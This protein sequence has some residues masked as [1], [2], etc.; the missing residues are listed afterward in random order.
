MSASATSPD[1]GARLR[2]AREARGVSLRQVANAT[3][4]AVGVLEAL[5]RNDFSKLPGGIFS[6]AF[7]RAYAQ[8]VGLDPEETVREFLAALP[9]DTS[10]AH[11]HAPPRPVDQEEAA[12]QSRQRMAAVALRL[13]LVSLPIAAALVYF[14]TRQADRSGAP[15]AAPR[16]RTSVAMPV[17]GEVRG[18]SE[19]ELVPRTGAAVS[20]PVAPQ[21]SP[22]A[23]GPES[24]DLVLEIAPVGICW[25]S[26]TADG[27]LVFARI[28]APGERVVQRI[29][30][31]AA[32]QVGDAG[33]FAFAINGRPG[34]PVGARGEVKRLRITRGNYETFLQ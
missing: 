30:E 33:A 1:F 15:P 27:R 28:L 22:P 21:A 24:G 2:Q 9:A 7:V 34:R 25:V 4:I 5:E 6:R 18:A 12:F 11:L 3:K 10:V 31:E 16:T 20:S 19:A 14:G 23:G 32:L 26:L 17:P 29:R 13:V 8:E